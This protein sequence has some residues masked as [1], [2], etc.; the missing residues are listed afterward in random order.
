MNYVS[1]SDILF[2]SPEAFHIITELKETKNRIIDKQNKVEPR[3]AGEYLDSLMEDSR[4]MALKKAN[5]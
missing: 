2:L 1:L 3:N 5:G 4:R